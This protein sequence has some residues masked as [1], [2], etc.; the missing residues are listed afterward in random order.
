MY[1]FLL[2]IQY[3]SIIGLIF[4]CM[5]VLKNSKN[6]AHSYLFQY[7]MAT[8]VNNAGY[9]GVMLSKTEGEAI[10]C[11]QMSYSGRVWI[12]FSLLM[13]VIYY[14]GQ[15]KRFCT[16]RSHVFLYLLSFC[17]IV[18]YILVLTMKYNTLYYSSFEFVNEGLFPHIRYSSGIWHHLYDLLILAYTVYGLKL[19]FQKYRTDFSPFEKQRDIFVSAAIVTSILFFI[20]EISGVG[21]AYDMTVLGYAISTVFIYIAI[22]RY[23]LLNTRDLARKFVVDRLSEAIVA[24]DIYGRIGFFNEPA[25]LL[26]PEIKDEPQKAVRRIKEIADKGDIFAVGERKYQ[27]EVNELKNGEKLSG[28]AYVFTDETDRLRY[29]EELKE[30]K[31]L[32]DSAN[33]AKSTFLANMSHDIRSPINA[34]LG[35]DEMILRESKENQIISYAYNIQT[36]GKTL[37]SLIND[38]LDLSKVEEGKMEII[39]VQYDLSS[40]VVDLVNLIQERAVK[41]GL[42]FELDVNRKIPCLL[43][44]D[45]IR[46]KQC[47]LNLLTNAVKY[48]KEGTVRM[49]VDF[50]PSD[51]GTILLLFKVKDTGIGI[52]QEDME[53]LFA[54]FTRIEEKRNRNIEGSG[55]GMSIV[56]KLLSLMG[57]ELAVSSVYGEGSEF[58]FEVKQEVVSKEEVGDITKRFN[59]TREHRRKYNELFHAPEARILV[60]DDTEINLDVIEHLLKRTLVQIDRAMSGYEALN[61]VKMHSYDCIFIDHVMP[62]M[63]GIET[64]QEMKKL[65]ET[66]GAVFIALTA[67][68]ISGARQMYLDAGFTNYLSKPVEGEKLERLLYECLPKEK[69]E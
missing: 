48:T 2:F 31:R 55:L 41:K 27:P 58:S 17:H 43:N 39:P 30:Q 28:T 3:A 52:K 18:T 15:E 33:R 24:V 6:H 1:H 51:N 22:F 69:I 36:A 68:A 16:R 53:K 42:K 26:F 25:A 46:I 65:K 44:G 29:I 45:E 7:S 34:V 49:S 35:M 47:V 63:D 57:S 9:L 23:R 62:E 13:F 10:L 32:A 4:E 61:L 37:L 8:M 40:M 64:L 67:N 50:E 59:E 54:A 56:Q 60:V 20:L 21:E 19:L 66:E 11:L 5:L 14:C 38:I 12:P